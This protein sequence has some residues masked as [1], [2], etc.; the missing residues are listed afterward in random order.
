M[1]Y[2]MLHKDSLELVRLSVK[3]YMEVVLKDEL[4]YHQACLV[5]YN[6]NT[7]QCRSLDD[8]SMYW[9]HDFNGELDESVH[10]S[11]DSAQSFLDYI[12]EYGKNMA[13]YHYNFTL[14]NNKKHVLGVYESGLFSS[15]QDMS[16]TYI[17]Q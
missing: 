2:Y 6:P 3:E 16:Y 12:S 14:N 10:T 17:N 4:E 15:S 7:N 8:I 11:E 1:K 13:L 5:L 9:F